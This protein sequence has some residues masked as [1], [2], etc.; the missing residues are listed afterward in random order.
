V[1][2]NLGALLGK[3]NSG[4][5]KVIITFAHFRRAAGVALLG[6]STL[7][8]APASAQDIFGNFFRLFSAPGPVYEQQHTPRVVAPRKVRLHP[9][10]VRPDAAAIKTSI[11]AKARAKVARVDA[12][13][14]KPPIKPKAPGEVTDPVP[15]LLADS[16]LRR[17]DIVMFP[18]GPRVFTGRPG[19][20]HALTDFVSVSRAGNA[21]PR[22]TRKLLVGLYPDRNGAWNT[23]KPKLADRAP[24]VEATGSVTSKRR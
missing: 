5:R 24:K 23:E 15:E 13:V 4:M 11:K 3:G 16:T 14:S 7:S 1:W 22:S 9:K 18:D 2:K 19:T 17:G 21:V 8:A 10:V 6:A 12:P 20:K